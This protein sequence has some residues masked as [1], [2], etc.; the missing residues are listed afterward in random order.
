M[1]IG[2]LWLL[3]KKYIKSTLYTWQD[4]LKLKNYDS[5]TSI[6]SF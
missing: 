2:Y 4:T 3:I 5:E 6:N 1:I